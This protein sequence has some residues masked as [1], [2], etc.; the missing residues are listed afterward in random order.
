MD[1]WLRVL[2]HRFGEWLGRRYEIEVPFSFLFC[3][4][5]FVFLFFFFFFFFCFFFNFSLCQLAT[6]RLRSW[7]STASPVLQ[8]WDKRVFKFEGQQTQFSTL[9]LVSFFIIFFVCVF[10]SFAQAAVTHYLGA[11]HM[12]E[13]APMPDDYAFSPDGHW[14]EPFHFYNMNKTD[15]QYYPSECPVRPKT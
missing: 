5:F 12:Y 9:V 14:S 4:G 7:L 13:V 1:D 8:R 3:E 10:S 2:A 15:T 11:M 6:K